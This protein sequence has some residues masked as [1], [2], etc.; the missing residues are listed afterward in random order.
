MSQSV[1]DPPRRTLAARLEDRDPGRFAGG[2]E[3]V[4]ARIDLG[5]LEAREARDLL[6]AHGLRDERV[7]DIIDWAAGSPLA[8]ALAADAATADSGWSAASEPERPEILRSLVL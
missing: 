6:A 4:T 3:S 5:P 8:L 1:Q 7:P 2:W